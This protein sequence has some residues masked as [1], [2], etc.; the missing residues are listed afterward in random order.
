MTEGTTFISSCRRTCAGLYT[1]AYAHSLCL[2]TY[3]LHPASLSPVESFT[4]K[5]KHIQNGRTQPNLTSRRSWTHVRRD[6]AP[7]DCIALTRQSSK[8]RSLVLPCRYRGTPVGTQI[9]V[10]G[11][12]TT[13]RK[14]EE[15]GRSHRPPSRL[16]HG[17]KQIRK[18]SV[19]TLMKLV[20]TPKPA[21]RS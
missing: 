12:Q 8:C 15:G 1:H 9:P 19:H 11:S 13:R 10:H 18:K 7:I 6:V 16:D 17:T 4:I 2:R 5:I 3:H 20:Q 14:T 21:R